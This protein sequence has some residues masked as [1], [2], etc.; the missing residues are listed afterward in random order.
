MVVKYSDL[1][2]V[3]PS[4]GDFSSQ[5]SQGKYELVTSQGPSGTHSPPSSITTIGVEL[6]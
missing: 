1:S 6:T 4:I 5:C 3:V 2:I